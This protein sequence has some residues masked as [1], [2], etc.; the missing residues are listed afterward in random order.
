MGYF[1]VVLML[2]FL[3]FSKVMFA[4]DGVRVSNAYSAEVLIHDNIKIVQNM[5]RDE[6]GTKTRLQAFVYK[7]SEWKQAWETSDS[8]NNIE[9]VPQRSIVPRTVQTLCDFDGDGT[10]YRNAY[11]I[12]NGKKLFS[13]THPDSS[14]PFQLVVTD[15]KAVK[16]LRFIAFQSA[17]SYFDMEEEYQEEETADVEESREEEFERGGDFLGTLFYTDQDQI[18]SQVSITYNYTQQEIDEVRELLIE[19]PT[20]YAT[21]RDVEIVSQPEKNLLL[22]SG[23]VVHYFKH[24]ENVAPTNNFSGIEI[25]IKFMKYDDENNEV[26]A[27]N[28]IIPIE[29]DR[30]AL[31]KSRD[32]TQLPGHFAFEQ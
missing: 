28:L 4:V 11:S 30:F 13:Y 27:G 6:L 8:C 7:D 20:I 5:T 19:A 9:E 23:D 16:R 10:Y 31:K 32:E 18:L 14:E 25:H 26:D 1:C 24:F 29:N 2:V 21:V 12:K 17:D 15:G 22:S 3:L